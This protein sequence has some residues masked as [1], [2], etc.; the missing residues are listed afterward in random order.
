VDLREEERVY[1]V[2]DSKYLR[3]VQPW[4]K[5]GRWAMSTHNPGSEDT[6]RD[7][8]PSYQSIL[9]HLAVDHDQ[10]DD[11][12]LREINYTSLLA[13]HAENHP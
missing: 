9:T 3:A 13:I 7:E 6:D 11:P 2:A 10:K 12:Q 1:F 5:I 8:F 4:S